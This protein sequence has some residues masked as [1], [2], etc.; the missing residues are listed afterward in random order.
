MRERIGVL[1][2]AFN[3]PHF[4][5]L[6]PALEAKALL[7]LDRLLFLPAGQHPFK[8]KE[9]LVPAV[10]RLAMV[11]LAIAPFAGCELSCLET[12]RA[13][14]GYTIDT[15]RRLEEMFPTAERFL[16]LGA[17]L[18]GELHLWREWQE[19]VRHAHLCVL[20]RPGGEALLGASAAAR[21]LAP[22]RVDPPTRLSVETQGRWGYGVLPV[23]PWD[24]SSTRVRQGL[25]NG[26]DLSAL[27][28]AEV[29][30]YIKEHRLYSGSPA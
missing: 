19:L 21:F 24:V 16:L 12:E 1:G 17:D 23:A 2:G 11:R 15:L 18:L 20:V 29:L 3:P 6:H 8:E 9:S 22:F 26:E 4:G 28:P 7:G 13:G 14:V 10:H 30:A 27:V 25:K 5:H